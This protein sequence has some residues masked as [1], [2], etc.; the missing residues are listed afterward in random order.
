VHD[1]VFELLVSK[2]AGQKLGARN[3]SE[4]EAK[5]LPRNVHSTTRNPGSGGRARRRLLV[6]RTDG[7]RVLT[8]VIEQAFDHGT[9]LVV[10]G[11]TATASER[12]ML[13]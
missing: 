1:I 6:G 8:L 2:V 10:T 9:W 13:S 3:I 5:Q 7:G 11:W 4:S 12:R